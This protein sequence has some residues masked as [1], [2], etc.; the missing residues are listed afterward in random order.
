MQGF[1]YAQLP[2]RIVFGAGTARTQLAAEVERLDATRVLVLASTR[3]EAQVAAITAP[4]GDR[5]AGTFTAVREHVP[6]CPRPRPR[7]PPRRRSTPMH[8]SRSAAARPSGPRRPS[9]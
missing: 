5:V 2:A 3:D 8:C 9:H 4:L 6:R 1:R 7:A